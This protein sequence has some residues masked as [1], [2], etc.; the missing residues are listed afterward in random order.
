[1]NMHAL[2]ADWSARDIPVLAATLA[3][4]KRLRKDEDKVMGRDISRVVLQDPL[5]TLRVLRYAQ[6]KRT[7]RQPTEITTVEH[8][9][10]MHGVTTFLRE[11]AKAAPLEQ[12]LVSNPRGLA[13]A[14]RVISRAHHAAQFARAIA[15][16]R[17]DI[18]TDEVIIGAL[19]HDLPE[20]LLWCYHEPAAS[21]IGT[22][23]EQAHGL[24]SASA[25]LAILGFT[26]V[27]LL[28][29]LADA[30]GLPQMLKNLMDDHHATRP[31]VRNVVIATA[32]ARHLSHGWHDLALPDDY[33]AMNKHFGIEAEHA[34]KMVRNASLNA[35]SH[36]QRIGIRPAAALLPLISEGVTVPQRP[37]NAVAPASEVVKAALQAIKS[38]PDGIDAC[39]A[40]ALAAQGIA[41]GIGL[42]R[43]MVALVDEK[44]RIA[45]CPFFFGY[46]HAAL[47]WAGF[48]FALN[49]RSLCGAL[50]SKPQALWAGGENRTKIDVLLSED[51]RLR[52]G[53]REFLAMSVFAKNRP[54]A[55]LIADFGDDANQVSESLMA[56]FKALCLALAERLARLSNSH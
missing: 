19:L 1:M 4:L 20:L 3:D 52:I 56:P 48:S 2:V 11:F 26:T 25:Q 29:G 40:A 14:L 18:E 23:L 5:M 24:R 44:Q 45:Y 31:R 22:L 36:W 15:T 27:D 46:G 50:M 32:L 17:H 21:A 7:S 38:A 10:M 37:H 9:V 30:W 51:E 35:A 55:L 34:Y 6:S 39:G 54:G 28:L 8:A 53:R 33:K 42:N 43:V 41:N 16:H 47:S 49:A 13:G 12:A